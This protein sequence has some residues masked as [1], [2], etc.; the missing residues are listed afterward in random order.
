MQIL[1]MGL[2][3]EEGAGFQESRQQDQTMGIGSVIVTRVPDKNKQPKQTKRWLPR[4][5]PFVYI[6]EKRMC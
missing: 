4:A 5:P 3:E 6:T 2:R 1:S